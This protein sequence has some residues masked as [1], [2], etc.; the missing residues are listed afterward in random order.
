MTDKKRGLRRWALRIGIGALSL[1]VVVAAAGGAWL[2]WTGIALDRDVARARAAGFVERD[3]TVD[4]ARIHYA[5]GPSNGKPALLLIHGQGMDWRGYAAVL[6]EL[7]RDFHVFAVDA[8]GHGRSAHDPALYSVV[9]HGQK[10]AA[11]IDQVIGEP[12]FVSGH[13]SG[14][15]L[16]AWV[17]GYAPD[18]VRGTLLE[19]PPLFATA[20]PRATTTWN[21]VDLATTCHGFLTSG[22]SDWVAYAWRHQRLWRFFGDSAASFID[23]GLTYHREH[24]GQAIKLWWAPQFNRGNELMLAYDPRFGDAF[25]TGSWNDGFDEAA[26]LK[27]IRP[28]VTLVHTKVQYDDE[29]ILMAAMGEEEASRARGLLVGVQFVKVE[30]GH[31]FHQEDP[32]HFVALLREVAKRT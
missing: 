14:G 7:A 9:T 8:F 26:T 2:W 29:G 23:E 5:E 15:V 11:F 27:A 17:A 22:E 3:A 21:Y 10:L 13:S 12:A 1:A 4:G 32:A 20:F 25:W 30:T 18:R 31:E 16:A 24:P 28:P 6:P 19:D